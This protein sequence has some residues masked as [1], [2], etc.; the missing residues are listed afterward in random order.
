M[1]PHTS[2]RSPVFSFVGG[3]ISRM[4]KNSVRDHFALLDGS[5][6]GKNLIRLHTVA[7]PVS[8]LHILDV[9]RVATF[10]NGDN[11]I[12]AR[13]QWMRISK[14][15]INRLSTNS[16]NGL[17]CINLLFISFKCKTV[18]P[19]LVRPVSFSCHSYTSF[20]KNTATALTMAV[21]PKRGIDA[22]S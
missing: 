20:I 1:P 14:R 5:A 2:D 10:C 8:Q 7:S 21:F 16:A 18:C 12:D 13:R 4:R 22:S 19:V 11:V 9:T 3:P 15:K 17:C 6:L